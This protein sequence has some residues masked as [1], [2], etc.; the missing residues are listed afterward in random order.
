[1][2]LKSKDAIRR[3]GHLQRMFFHFNVSPNGEG[4]G[5]VSRH[6]RGKG[7]KYCVEMSSGNWQLTQKCP[8]RALLSGS[9]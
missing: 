9:K 5:Q 7:D 8:G 1:M 2:D 6:D 4:P 3:V